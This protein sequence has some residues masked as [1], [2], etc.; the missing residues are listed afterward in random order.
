MAFPQPFIA[1]LLLLVMAAGLVGLVLPI[2]PGLV[3]IWLA[4]LG[5]GILEGFTS[6]GWV[7]LGLVT[8]LMITG[9]LIDNVIMSQQAH[10]NGAAWYSILIAML[11][12]VVGSFLLP[13][14]GGL[15][16]ALTALFLVE[17]LRHRNWR[18]AFISTRGWAEG[19][20]WAFLIRFLMGLLM[21]GLSVI[22]MLV[23]P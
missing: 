21:I 2:F 4:S 11:F 22:W 19:W 1:S 8:L 12:G 17:W 6:V 3:V 15:L 9:S 5:Y 20:G 16:G 23:W 14:L 13:V 10:E 7:I 18:S